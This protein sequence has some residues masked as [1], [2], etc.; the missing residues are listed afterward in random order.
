MPIVRVADIVS[1]KWK[2]EACFYL[3]QKG[4]TYGSRRGVPLKREKV[5]YLAIQEEKCQ[6]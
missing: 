6:Q 2:I 3:I 4:S 5:V 1:I